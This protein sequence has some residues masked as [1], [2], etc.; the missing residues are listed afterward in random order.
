MPNTPN[1]NSSLAKKR[2]LPAE[3]NNS[4]PNYLPLEFNST[5]RSGDNLEALNNQ[6]YREYCE[7]INDADLS[8]GKAVSELCSRITTCMYARYYPDL[9]IR[10]LGM[11][12][13]KDWSIFGAPES[14]LPIKLDIKALESFS[15]EIAK[16]FEYCADVVQFDMVSLKGRV[17]ICS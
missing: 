13:I 17:F 8:T 16:S 6:L 9:E 4:N 15:S 7:V 14:M 2:K 1:S 10:C 3:P 11:E 12:A 5:K